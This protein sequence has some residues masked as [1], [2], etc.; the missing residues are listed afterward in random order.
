MFSHLGLSWTSVS[1]CVI[2]NSFPVRRCIG[3]REPLVYNWKVFTSLCRQVYIAEKLA[4]PTSLS[5]WIHAYAKIWSRATSPAYYRQIAQ[6]GEWSKVAVYVSHILGVRVGVRRGSQRR[7]HGSH[8]GEAQDGEEG[9]VMVNTEAVPGA[10][11][12]GTLNAVQLVSCVPA[13]R[14]R[15][16][17][18]LH[19]RCRLAVSIP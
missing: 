5:T 13:T 11:R 6:S 15:I 8:W 18:I 1:L 4:P 10:A 12:E 2:R 7:D 9:D 14:A 17:R 16:L 19:P 3:Y